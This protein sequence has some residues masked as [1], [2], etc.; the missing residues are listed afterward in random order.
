[1]KKN[2]YEYLVRLAIPQDG[3]KND[4]TRKTC[5]RPSRLEEDSF[6]STGFVD[7]LA[8]SGLC[9]FPLV[10]WIVLLRLACVGFHWFQSTVG[11]NLRFVSPRGCFDSLP[12]PGWF[13]STA[14]FCARMF[15]QRLS[16]R[17]GKS[18]SKR[19]AGLYSCFSLEE[20]ILS[21]PWNENR[22]VEHC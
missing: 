7:C 13:Q 18:E 9:W 8:S 6:S 15:R 21:L 19:R 16:A 4:L 5:K 10:S 22:T 11:F 17:T 14:C 12:C 20:V 2:L 3:P 1:M